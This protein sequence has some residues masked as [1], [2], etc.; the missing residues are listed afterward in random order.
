MEKQNKKESF[1]FTYSAREQEEIKKIRQK[2][3]PKE[4]K[5]EQLR[6]LDRSVTQK[7]TVC[8]LVIGVIGSLLLGIGM[9]CTMV[10][11]TVWFV[12]GI[13]V[14]I[15]GICMMVIAYPIYSHVT[16]KERE[17]IAPQILRLTDDLLK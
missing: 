13:V 2:Y 4:D 7:G 9:C 6:R 16:E 3:L 15:L 17:K 5:M 8:S 14:G 10:W 12:P 11:N 1:N